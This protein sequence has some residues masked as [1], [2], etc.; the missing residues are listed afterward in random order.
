MALIFNNGGLCFLAVKGVGKG[1]S[2]LLVL[3]ILL[4]SAQDALSDQGANCNT[5]DQNGGD[6]RLNTS[7]V[8]GSLHVVLKLLLA[9]HVEENLV[10]VV[11]RLVLGQVGVDRLGKAYTFVI[12]VED[13]VEV[14]EE[15]DTQVR[16]ASIARGRNLQHAVSISIDDV[17]VLGDHIVCLLYCESQVWHSVEL[18][19]RAVGS[20]EA[21]WVQ[22]GLASAVDVVH[23]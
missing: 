2:G 23:D 8:A 17:L 15:V 7:V 10:R 3:R 14:L 19:N 5:D 22:L 1:F 13:T 6:E 16:F 9:A 20:P 21:H 18:L 4:C 11:A 12:H